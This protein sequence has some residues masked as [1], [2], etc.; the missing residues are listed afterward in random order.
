M[1]VEEKIIYN[2]FEFRD[3]QKPIVDAFENKKYRKLLL[4]MPRRCVAPTT[5]ITMH[6]STS[7]PITDI[8]IGDKILAFDG[9][10][11]V[12][13]K[14]YNVWQSGFKRMVKVKAENRPPV[15]TSKDHRFYAD[16]RFVEAINL[17]QENLYILD[18]GVKRVERQ[19]VES[20][21]DA[22]RIP[23]YDIQT[24]TYSNFFANGY[25][26]HNSG[27]DIVALQLAIR[28]ALRRTCNIFYVFP[29]AIQ[30]RKAIW[31]A[32][33]I[34][35]RNI[36]DLVPKQ[37]AK[38]NQTEMKL[39]FLNG[40]TIQFVGSN[41]AGSRL[42]GSNP[43]LVIFSEFAFADPESYNVIRPI[44]AAN[45][46]AV[47]IQSC[48]NPETIVMSTDGLTRIKDISTKRSEYSP[49]NKDIY[50]LQ[51]FHNAT[52]FYY[53]GKQETLKITL[54][55]GYKIECTP[56][57]RLWNGYK[58][59]KSKDLRIGDYIPVQYGQNVFGKGIDIY[60]MLEN[61]KH[62]GRCS[63]K[64]YKYNELDIFYLLG[65]IHGDGN[66]DRGRIMITNKRD[67]EIR[68]FLRKMGFQKSFDDMHFRLGAARLAFIMNELGFK[69]GAKNK[70]YPEGLLRANREQTI[71][72]LA[73]C[74]DSD[75]TSGS[76]AVHISSANED[77]I[78]TLQIVLLNLGIVSGYRHVHVMPTK[79]VNVESDVYSLG[80][81]GYYAK[82]FYETI[83]L[84]VKRKW[85]KNKKIMNLTDS[86]NIMPIPPIEALEVAPV[87]AATNPYRMNRRTIRK[88]LDTDTTIKTKF[89][90]AL[91]KDR[92][93]LLN[94]LSEKLHYSKIVKIEASESEVFDFVIPDTHSFFSN[95]FI[96]HNTPNGKNRFY[97][98]Y[99]LAKNS[100]DWFYYKKTVDDTQ[101]I[102]P[103][104]LEL[105]RAQMSE[106]M[107]L[108]EYYTSFNAGARGSYYGKII[109][110]LELDRRITDVPWEPAHPVHTAWDLGFSD[111]TVIIFFQKIGTSVHIIDF[112]E[113]SKK[114]LE[115][116]IRYLD[117]KPYKYGTHI[118]PHDIANHSFTTG[119]TRIE[120]ARNLGVDFIV[121]PNIPLMDGIEAVRVLLPKCYFDAVKTKDLITH[122]S[123]YHQ[124]WDSMKQTYKGRP[125]HD[126]HSHACDSMRY[127]AISVNKLDTGISAQELRDRYNKAMYGR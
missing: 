83:P 40:S 55:S 2:K 89:H 95:G 108:Q 51:G 110:Q 81:N 125:S 20:V 44:L 24:E 73:G 4:V 16:D 45:G 60:K 118:A 96:S 80:I 65:L 6:D 127:L 114:P 29:T 124:E 49:L 23:S 113:N 112:Y 104:E 9:K 21:L 75:G 82:I 53:G 85:K 13:D 5:L 87:D 91:E 48:V 74:F 119:V 77:F 57:H 27:K 120:T 42:R 33:S 109:N 58:W 72:F 123:L 99:Q 100:D 15:H 122:L 121:A 67:K 62:H 76:K 3:Y 103:Y 68:S 50:G 98:L 92:E 41:D 63:D 36:L 86:G 8:R 43:Y 10:N 78:K 101:H 38:R 52:H 64:I 22:G 111:N 31:D 35:G 11:V 14:V 107:F 61:Y 106:D 1:N 32:V 47:I 56:I 19:R 71:S 28:Q 26:V 94:I 30:A 46:G 70:V 66:Y 84:R 54:S 17:S 90:I 88:I 34:D 7:K 25:L 126:L 12:T 102:D 39:T 37:I 117:S 69:H 105:E 79:K 116:Y 115:H 97:D 93:I 18:A 59:I